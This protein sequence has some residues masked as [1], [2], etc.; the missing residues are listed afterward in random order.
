MPEKCL[1]ENLF[2]KEKHLHFVAKKLSKRTSLFTRFL[3]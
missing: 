2:K 1:S 3:I